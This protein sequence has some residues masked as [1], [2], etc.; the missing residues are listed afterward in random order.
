MP[1]GANGQ[2]ANAGP[3]VVLAHPGPSPGTGNGPNPGVVV[4]AAAP[5]EFA[6]TAKALCCR[7]ASGRFHFRLKKDGV[8]VQ[9]DPIRSLAESCPPRAYESCPPEL[10]L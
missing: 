3:P 1:L 4:V 8:A 9:R 7:M 5:V 10:S 2:G 6:A